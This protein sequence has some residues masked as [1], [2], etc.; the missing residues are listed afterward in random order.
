MALSILTYTNLKSIPDHFLYLN[1][2][3]FIKNSMSHFLTGVTF[4][5]CQN[6]IEQCMSLYAL[7]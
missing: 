4:D 1:I 5:S 6:Q 7:F 3:F 2:Q